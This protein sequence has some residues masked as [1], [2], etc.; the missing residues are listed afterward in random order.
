[1]YLVAHKAHTNYVLNFS[2]SEDEIKH[3]LRTLSYEEF[4]TAIVFQG[5][6]LD[7]ER[8]IVMKP[9]GNDETAS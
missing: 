9:R 5:E 8:D 6:R 7:V 3:Y 2:D 1:M 4:R